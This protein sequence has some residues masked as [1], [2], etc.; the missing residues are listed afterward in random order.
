MNK[1]DASAL[2]RKF[3]TASGLPG[4]QKAEARRALDALE[5]RAMPEDIYKQ[6][7]LLYH[8]IGGLANQIGLLEPTMREIFRQ[9]TG[10]DSRTEMTDDELRKV[11]QR[12]A[13]E[14][15]AAGDLVGIDV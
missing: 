1:E 8:Q 5:R 6:R 3:I 2:L 12:M 7:V 13:R 9:E 15:S 11:K 10:K 4:F 14:L